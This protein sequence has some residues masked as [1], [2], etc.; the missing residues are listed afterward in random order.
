M[1]RKANIEFNKRGWD[2]I[3][4]DVIDNHGVP[5]M[6]R[7]ADAANEGLEDPEGYQVSVQG[8]DPLTKRDYR[9]TVITTT[10]EAMVDNAK[11]NTLIQDFHL[12]GGD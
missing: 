10:A 11:R 8:D 5:R 12:A 6:Q 1:T 7:V 9:A 4:K 3:V 2:Q